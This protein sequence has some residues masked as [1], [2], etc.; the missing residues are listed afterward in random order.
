MIQLIQVLYGMMTK[1]HKTLC[2]IGSCPMILGDLKVIIG[3]IPSDEFRKSIQ[4]P[5]SVDGQCSVMHRT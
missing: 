5:W 4:C 1:N 3:A 2:R